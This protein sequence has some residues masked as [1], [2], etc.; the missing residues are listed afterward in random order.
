MSTRKR[1][2]VRLGPPPAWRAKALLVGFAA[3]AAAL[4]VRAFELQ[5][6]D[7]EFLTEEGDKR[8]VRTLEVPAVR[9]AIRDRHGQPLALSAPT[10]SVWAVPGSVL[11]APREIAR[12]ARA[13]NMSPAALRSRLKSHRDRQFLYLK[14]QLDPAR[15][16]TI[17]DMGVP[18]VFLQREYRRF[19]PAGEAAAQLVGLTDIDGRGQEGLELGMDQ[20]LR[21]VA[22]SR[23]VIKDRLG[24]VVE[25]LAEFQAPEPGGDV[26]LTV[27]ARL[28]YLAYRELKGAVMEH[29]ARSGAVTMIDPDDGEVLAMA[30]Y[31]SFNPNN[32]STIEA[33]ALRQRAAIDTFEPGST[34]KPLL[35]AKAL[36]AG[37]VNDE[38]VVD[39]EGGTMQVGNLTV[40]DF[41][42]Y[43]DVDLR[44]LLVKSSNV[45]AA[46][47]GLDI[48]PEK[49]WEAYD[50]LGFGRQSGV[51]FP[52]ERTGVLRDYYRW[53]EVHTATASYGY[54]VSVTALQLA[55]AYGAL[56]DNGRLR[57]LTLVGDRDAVRV[58]PQRVLP[59]ETTRRVRALLED[60]ISPE[61]T[62]SRADV[63]GYRVAG[64]TGTVRKAADGGYASD[65]HQALFVGM[66]P[67]HDPEVVAVV[68]VDEPTGDA[69]YGGAVA[70]PVFARIMDEAVRYLGI[71]P[72]DP[73]TLTAAAA[74]GGGQS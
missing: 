44:R 52:G 41:R 38:R 15:A 55:R 59:A 66:L 69:Y 8:H 10:E 31:P 54:G 49:V 63:P 45:G 40:R 73:A 57:S 53:G 51:R 70:A 26:Q 25:D 46:K 43:G 29:G 42:D 7:R 58:P 56:A 2:N 33:D 27:D 65:R 9:G 3:F 22:G 19:Y 23:Q 37:A 68:I 12:L 74:A 17:K 16:R 24:H 20:R 32:R 47:I 18:G 67:A 62:G 34:F 39:T 5:V 35:I 6:L 36:A 50:D 28:Q 64:K 60:V 71:P 11:E 61:G 14:R 72:D 48:G 4:C 1:L 13:L 30:S 21:G